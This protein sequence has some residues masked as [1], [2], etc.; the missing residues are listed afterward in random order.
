M[1][2]VPSRVTNLVDQSSSRPDLKCCPYFQPRGWLLLTRTPTTYS[3]ISGANDLSTLLTYAGAGVPSQ[4]RQFP[5]TAAQ[6]A[7]W[8]VCNVTCNGNAA[9]IRDTVFGLALTAW[10]VGNTSTV[11]PVTYETFDGRP[12]QTWKLERLD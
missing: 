7:V 10:P 8:L 2:C 5:Q 3:I 1:A 4:L 11:T 6:S 9:V 12:E